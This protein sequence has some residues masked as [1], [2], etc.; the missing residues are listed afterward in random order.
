LRLP[1]NASGIHSEELNRDVRK[2]SFSKEVIERN[3]FNKV[4]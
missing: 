3:N 2:F 1:E 4:M